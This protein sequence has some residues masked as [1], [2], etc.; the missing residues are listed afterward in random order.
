MGVD[1]RC[2]RGVASFS[3]KH[4]EARFDGR[5]GRKLFVSAD[6]WEG[7]TLT[8]KATGTFI[9][10]DAAHFANFEAERTDRIGER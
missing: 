10:V 9:S 1:G 3:G 6:L 5:E 2:P 7:D 4:F 8:V